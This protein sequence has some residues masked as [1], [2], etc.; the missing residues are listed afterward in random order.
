MPVQ[1]TPIPDS[2]F[3]VSSAILVNQKELDYRFRVVSVS[4]VKEFGK[5]SHAE[6][7]LL[8]GDVA[9]GKFEASDTGELSI[10]N[11]IE[12]QAG[13]DENDQTV[14]KGIIVKQTIKVDEESSTL[15]VTAKNK[16]CK[17]AAARHNEVY[18]E[19][20]DSKIIKE[21][22]ERSGLTS[23]VG[24]TSFEH[25][26]LT[27]YNCSDWDFINIRAEVNSMLVYTGDDSMIVSKPNLK[28]ETKLEINYGSTIFD[29]EAELDG[30]NAFSK[31]MAATWN[32]IEQKVENVSQENGTGET[33]QGNLSSSDMASAMKNDTCEIPVQSTFT[34]QTELEILLDSMVL[35]YNLSRI[36]GR[37]KTYGFADIHPGDMIDLQR[38][39]E[40]FNG[41]T[42]VSG[43]EHEIAE[44]GWYTTIRFGMDGSEYA[45]K[46]DDVNGLQASGMLPAIN[47]LQ[48]AKVMQFQ[49]DPED[50]G[51][52]LVRLS[53]FASGDQEGVWARIA[54]FYA[55]DKRG[56]FF[57]PEID[58]EVIVGFID[59]HP[60]N[61][62]ILGSL[63]SSSLPP[64]Q[65]TDDNNNIKGIYTKSGIKLEFDDK[66]TS[67]SVT[68]PKGNV[69]SI[70]D[71]K[72]ISLK[73]KKGNSIVMD[74]DGITIEASSGNVTL[75]GKNVEIEAQGSFIAKG[76]T[77]AE[78]ST[79]AN[80]V[81]KGSMV[82]IN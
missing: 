11:D 54:T 59:D 61:A 76:N 52:I 4:V 46:Y 45:K 38:V 43:V 67:F 72:S 79:S 19:K 47:G 81:I 29:F 70:I 36:T 21:I 13:Y 75:K 68:T 53:N 17:M 82:Q 34:D 10:G 27:Q 7:V 25:K 23:E 14:F 78:L 6:I 15:M 71:D 12:I 18:T 33:S 50:E 22:I 74:S 73:D 3:G 2:N 8:D 41:K 64:P 77:G 69:F 28:G 65:Q 24:D 62:V 55:G 48:T 39:G 51:R 9:T 60:D 66:E 31:Y 5:I 37:I 44:G 35:R 63:N 56:S 30:S 16:A 1:K 42:I 58:D 20:S 49:D 80:A 40:R 57:L 26:S 32:F